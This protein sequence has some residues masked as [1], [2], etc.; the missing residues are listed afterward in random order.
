MTADL[1]RLLEAAYPG[2]PQADLLALIEATPNRPEKSPRMT[3]DSHS[4]RAG[5]YPPRKPQ[6][7]PERAKSIERRRRL[8]SSGPLPPSTACKFTVSEQ[9]ILRIIGDEC[10]DKGACLLHMDAIAARAGTCRKMV[11]ITIRKAAREGLLSIQERRRRGQPNLTNVLKVASREWRMWLDRGPSSKRIGGKNLPAPDTKIQRAG[12]RREKAAQASGSTQS[13]S[14]I[15]T[16]SRPNAT[17]NRDA[18][19]EP[20]VDRGPAKEMPGLQRWAVYGNVRLRGA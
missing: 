16:S 20:G 13:Q 5:I 1:L 15:Q 8:A 12:F 18:P 4:R 14:P 2:R 11:Q 19:P 7:S 10:R 9:A 17:Q 3:Q 6:G